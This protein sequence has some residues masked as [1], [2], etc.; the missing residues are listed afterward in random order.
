MKVIKPLFFSHAILIILFLAGC[1]KLIEVNAPV[2]QLSTGVVFSDP[3][4]ADGAVA[5]IYYKLSD[6]FVS[7][8]LTLITSMGSDEMGSRNVF[9]DKYVNNAIPVNDGTT[10]LIWSSLYNAIYQCNSVLEGISGS[11]IS[12]Q[13]KKQLGGEAK[14]LRAFCYFY[15]TNLWGD[16]PLLTSTQ[17]TQS[18]IALRSKQAAVY[19]QMIKDLTEASSELPK[20]YPHTERVRANSFAASALLSRIYLYQQQWQ[21]AIDE[22]SKVI[23]AGIYSLDKPN[24]AFVKNSRETILQLWMQNGCAWL[25]LSFIP[26]TTNGSSNYFLNDST[27][28]LFDSSDLRK[29]NWIKTF[30]AQSLTYSY[31][32]KYKLR[33]PTQ[34]SNSEYTM[35]LRLAEQLLI[36][37]EA[38]AELNLITN[39]LEDLNT[40]RRR[41][42]ASEIVS[43]LSKDEVLFA[44]D[45]ERRIELF[46]EWGHR[47][48]DIKRTNKADSVLS[49]VKPLWKARS[50][51]W[52]IPQ[53]EILK[54]PQLTQNPGY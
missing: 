17:V 48:L 38:R 30:T 26:V 23:T 1:K 33:I 34:G 14:F 12:S 45:R 3:S 2:D 27:L 6:L 19:E 21:K 46:A 44:I 50:V 7:R 39:A 49:L 36:R 24:E 10:G 51:L 52:P 37:A 4:T 31:P 41:A 42:N 53:Q 25:G 28:Q 5:G 15:L 40:V 43:P 54:N 18:A 8:S 9:D 22:A 32:F 29:S 11:N 20:A 13:T 35:V 47:W 16:V